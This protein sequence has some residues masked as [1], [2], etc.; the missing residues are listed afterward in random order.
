MMI[1]NIPAAA[2]PIVALSFQL[3][4]GGIEYGDPVV[5]EKMKKVENEEEEVVVDLVGSICGHAVA[6]EKLR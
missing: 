3:L 1:A 5:F 2:I 4:V 6:P